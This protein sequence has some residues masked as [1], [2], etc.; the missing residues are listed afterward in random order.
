MINT[1]IFASHHWHN[2][3]VLSDELSIILKHN[4]AV[5]TNIRLR[6]KKNL[7]IVTAEMAGEPII[8]YNDIAIETD[9]NLSD[10]YDNIVTQLKQNGVDLLHFHNV[11]HGSNLYRLM[12]NSAQIIVP[13]KAP[14]VQLSNFT[15]LNEY[16][17]TL[18]ASTRKS[19]RRAL[20]KLE[21][22]YKVEFNILIDNQI[23][24]A[25]FDQVIQ[26]KAAQ[27]K[28]LGLTSRLFNSF[29]EISK[30]R[31]IISKKDNNFQ[32]VFSLL[33]CDGTIAAAEIGYI[34]NHIYYSFLGAMDDRFERFSPGGCQLLKTMEWA[35][36]NDI[37]IFDFLAPEDSYKSRWAGQTYTS[38]CDIISPLSFK[39]KIGG[40][41][42]KTIRPTLKNAYLSIKGVRK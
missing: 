3:N 40:L 37:K 20:K 28:R 14:Y 17:A 13:K 36:K 6:V 33:E 31:D 27:L 34:Q 42:L 30:L 32:C 16:L 29:A 7:G 8:Q 41:Y 19:K 35:I 2:A 25:L 12:E 21:N 1:N 39:G 22:T 15:N 9:D 4:N 23:S 38:V 10:I 24:T 26:L 5:E 11:R 18:S